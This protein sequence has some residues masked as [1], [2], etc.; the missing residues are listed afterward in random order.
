MLQLQIPIPVKFFCALIYSNEDIYL[1]TKLILQKKFGKIDF[2]SQLIPFN[3]TDY[4]SKEMGECLY[5]RFISFK[6][7]RLPCKF[8]NIKLYCIK[9]EKLF[10][11]KN[12]R[13]INIDPGYI[14]ESKLVLTTTKD[15]S[16]RIYLKKG[17]FAEIT[18]SFINGK[19]SN[20][21]TTFPDYR[22]DEY[23]NIFNIIREKYRNDIKD[24]YGKQNKPNK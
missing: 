10:S 14:N 18:L 21:P 6:K 7:L 11:S 8:A 16:H 22:T 12:S 4:Y 15:F 23:K 2:E 9:L 20:W 19:F 3:F 5:R 1:K 17:I 13:K 24:K